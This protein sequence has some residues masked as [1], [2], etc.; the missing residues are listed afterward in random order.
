MLRLDGTNTAFPV[1][2]VP[3]GFQTVLHERGRIRA[4]WA[5]ILGESMGGGGAHGRADG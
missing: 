4:I 1:K 3:S 5:V 2:R